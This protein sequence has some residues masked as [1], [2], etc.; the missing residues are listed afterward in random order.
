MFGYSKVVGD[1]K[2][3]FSG[4]KQR[5]LNNCIQDWDSTIR[6]KDRYFPY[7]HAKSVF[8]PEQYLSLLEKCCFRVRLCQLRLGVFPINNTL[9]RLSVLEAEIVCFV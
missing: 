4:L 8:K 7:R 9:H 3:F 5:L 2:R 6:D 1:E